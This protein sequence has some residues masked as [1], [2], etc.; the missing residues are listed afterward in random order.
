MAG[1]YEFVVGL[2]DN[3]SAGFARLGQGLNGTINSTG[4][5]SFRMNEINASLG[6]FG[7]QFN[8]VIAPGIEYEKNMKEV[9]AI[10]GVAGKGL[11]KLG[12]NARKLSEEFGGTASTGLES[13][14]I[15]LSKLDPELA[16]NAQAMDMMGRE[17]GMLARTMGGDTIGATTALTTAMNSY[18]ISTK[19]PIQ[20]S[21]T[22]A[23]M[24]DMIAK[25][26]QVGSAEVPQITSALESLGASASSAGVGFAEAQAALQVLDKYGMKKGAEGGIALRNVLIQMGEGEFMPKQKREAIQKMGVSLKVLGD[27]AIPLAERLKELS[28]IQG[29]SALVSEFFGKENSVAGLAMLQNIGVL[30]DYTSKIVDSSGTT[31]QMSDVIGSSFAARMSR[32]GAVMSNYGI[33]IFEATKAYLPMIQTTGMLFFGLSQM[34]PALAMMG[35]GLLWVGKQTLFATLATA[36]YA[37][38]LIFTTFQGLGAFT[39]ALFRASTWQAIMARQTYLNIGAM[40]AQ[41][42]AMV[43]ATVGTWALSAATWVL[44]GGMWA[45]MSPVLA[46]IAGL[47][48]LGLAVY[49]IYQNWEWLKGYIF[50]FGQ[51]LVNV[52]I[53]WFKNNPISMLVRG[54][55][56]IT[57]WFFPGFSAKFYKFFTDIGE[58]LYGWI[59]WIWDGISGFFSSIGKAIGT[60][61]DEVGKTVSKV[62]KLGDIK[63]GTEGVGE[64]NK[65]LGNAQDMVKGIGNGM[66][67]IS[68]L[69]TDKAPKDIFSSNISGGVSGTPDMKMDKGLEGVS[70]GGAKP[71]T[72]NITI[73]KL[74]ETISIT[75]TNLQQGTAEIE[76][77]MLQ[78][79]MRVANSANQTTGQ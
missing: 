22:M 57:D 11:E 5:F 44:A 26:A 12:E 10:T 71:T 41:R 13:Y 54:I 2:R 59:K 39:I 30:K 73:G 14:K 33:K 51:M 53:W 69:P 66:E 35:S 4:A 18:G 49:G 70:G 76:A 17:V 7:N 48:G 21:R 40:I 47:A 64:L 23:R 6:A 37:G 29:N 1:Y 9:Q 42:L 50:A 46:V 72:I 25:G 62:G 58:W 63:I 61:G 31:Q 8:A 55:I 38:S 28:K 19:D 24:M 79:L 45:F 36:R 15:I 74:N 60:V 16:K 65:G 20:A 32:V 3:F 34:Y 27:K 75:T 67:N 52:G 68:G 77:M 43:G 78:L 56:A